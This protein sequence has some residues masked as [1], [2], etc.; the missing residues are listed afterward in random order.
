MALKRFAS[1]TAHAWLHGQRVG[2]RVPGRLAAEKNT[3]AV[4]LA[5]ARS[6]LS[7]K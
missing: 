2:A 7:Q 6:S 3:R 4:D 5:A 1:P